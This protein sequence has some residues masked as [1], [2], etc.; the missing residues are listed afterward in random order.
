M[1]FEVR[2]STGHR[3]FIEAPSDVAAKAIALARWASHG[4][5]PKGVEIRAVDAA[6]VRAA[7]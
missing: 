3:I 7:S 1:R 2:A 6:R 4:I 5:N